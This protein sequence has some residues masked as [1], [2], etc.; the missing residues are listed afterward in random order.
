M[1]RALQS[2][3]LLCV[4]SVFGAAQAPTPTAKMPHA[5]GEDQN[6]QVYGGFLYQPTDWGPA[7]DKY[8][9]VEV[10]YTR[11]FHRRW[12][13]VFDFDWTKNDGSNIA[14]LDR[15]ISHNS[16]EW[17]FRGGPRYNLLVNRRFQPYLVGLFGGAHFTSRVP[18]PGHNGPIVQKDW[19]G[20]TYGG[21]GGV[22]FKVTHHFGIRGQWDFTYVPWGTEKTDSSHW[23][24]ISF[25]GTYRW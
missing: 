24:R 17:A 2:V 15:G 4:L 25:G 19:F 18:Y 8:Y 16:T 13:G 9:G 22:D 10:N 11:T 7:W 20:F 3:L 1:K 5:P 21:G 14:D 6:N 12:G 23:D